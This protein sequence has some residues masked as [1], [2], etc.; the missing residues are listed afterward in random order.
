MKRSLHKFGGIPGDSLSV[1]FEGFQDNC[2]IVLETV[3]NDIDFSS[4]IS[5]SFSYISVG[6]NSS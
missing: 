6:V 4:K 3:D 1:S 5:T 2:L